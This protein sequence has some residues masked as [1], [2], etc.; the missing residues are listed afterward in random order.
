MTQRSTP[1]KFISTIHW[2]RCTGAYDHLN[3]VRQI[4]RKCCVVKT[5]DANAYFPIYNTEQIAFTFN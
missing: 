3:V 4:S 1:Q 5:I 2:L